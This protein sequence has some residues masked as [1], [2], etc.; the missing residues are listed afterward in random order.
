MQKY[1]G[2]VYPNSTENKKKFP[3]AGVVFGIV[4]ALENRVLRKRFNASCSH[5]YTFT[6]VK[7]EAG[8]PVE[9]RSSNEMENIFESFLK[10]LIPIDSF[11]SLMNLYRLMNLLLLDSLNQKAILLTG[12]W[13]SLLL[14]MEQDMALYM[15]SL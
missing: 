8:F 6:I 14:P 13:L 1:Q 3:D 9:V 2:R 11:D 10:P 5:D 12:K 7:S 4:D 15:I